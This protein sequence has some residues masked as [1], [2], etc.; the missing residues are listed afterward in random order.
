MCNCDYRDADAILRHQVRRVSDFY[1]FHFNRQAAGLQYLEQLQCLL[2]QMA[3]LGR[4][5]LGF[6]GTGKPKNTRALLLVVAATSA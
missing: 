1:Q 6:Q 3:T 4:E 2:A 5:Q